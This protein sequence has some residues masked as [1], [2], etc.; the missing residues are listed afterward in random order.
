MRAPK[1]LSMARSLA[2]GTILPSFRASKPNRASVTIY[3]NLDAKVGQAATLL[4]MLVLGSAEYLPLLIM[5][6]LRAM[7]PV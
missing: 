2:Q 3:E 1:V 7:R 5:A 6:R 4:G